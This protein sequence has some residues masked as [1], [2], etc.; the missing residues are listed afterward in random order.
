MKKSWSRLWS[1]ARRIRLRRK[2]AGALEIRIGVI[3][4]LVWVFRSSAK[5]EEDMDGVYSYDNEF[6]GY[7]L[8]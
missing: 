7:D 2:N 6:Q 1:L 5:G 3:N 8:I 4:G